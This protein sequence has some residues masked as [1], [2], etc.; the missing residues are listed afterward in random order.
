[1]IMLYQLHVSLYPSMI[2]I[3]TVRLYLSMHAGRVHSWF[4]SGGALLEVGGALFE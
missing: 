1:M 3:L 2:C 4:V